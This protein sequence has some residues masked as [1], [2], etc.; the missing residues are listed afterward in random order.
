LFTFKG[1]VQEHKEKVASLQSILQ[2]TQEKLNQHM[3]A[4][5]E[6]VSAD[7]DGIWHL[8]KDI[9]FGNSQLYVK[10]VFASIHTVELV[11]LQL[12][13][14]GREILITYVISGF[15]CEVYENCTLLG[16]YAASSGNFDICRTMH[17]YIFL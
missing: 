5:K 2:T 13:I 11:A 12:N 3:S 1:T 17:H 15:R 8:D 9:D 14:W 7:S 4:G 10:T 6:Q 16:Y